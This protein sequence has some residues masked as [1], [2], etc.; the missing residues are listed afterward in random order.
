V[1]HGAVFHQSVQGPVKV[2]PPLFLIIRV[3]LAGGAASSFYGQ[4]KE[5]RNATK[6]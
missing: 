3:H 2:V 4:L 5:E 6:L 1:Q